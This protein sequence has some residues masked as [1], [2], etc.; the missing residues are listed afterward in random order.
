MTQNATEVFT[1]Q[2][3][4]TAGTQADRFLKARGLKTADRDDVIGAAMLWCWE[5]RASYSLTTTL[6]T[7]FMNAVRNAYQDL[8]RHELPTSGDSIDQI[9]SGE[10]PTYSTVAAESSAKALIDALVPVDKEIALLLMQGYTYRE[11]NRRGYANDAING[12][13]KRIKQLRRLVPDVARSKRMLQTPPSVDSDNIAVEIEQLDFPPH[14]GKD[15]PPCWRCMWFE[16]FMP[17][18][19]RSTRLDI[20]DVEVREA[21]KNTEA[22]K[23]EIA[24]QVRDGL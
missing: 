11:I 20:E 21:V 9:S 12:A 19:K 15:C 22:R 10:D 24:Q 4:R 6:E 1:M 2:L 18:G 23:V 5:N 13:Q 7:W 14:H 17:A 16:G 8:R 3:A